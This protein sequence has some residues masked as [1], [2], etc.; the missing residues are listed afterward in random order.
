MIDPDF[1]PKTFDVPGAKLL[2]DRQLAFLADWAA[3]W[4]DA[5][6]KAA[7]SQ[8][9]FAG[10]ATLHGAELFRL[11][12][13][14]DC[15]GWPQT[16]R[17]QALHE[18]RRGFAFMVGGDQH[19]STIVHHGIDDWNDAGWSFCVP[20]I[21]NF[22]PRAWVP[23]TPGGNR[24][25]GMPDYTGKFLDGLGNHVTVWAATNPGKPTGRE[26][27][28]LHDRM[29][30]YGIVRFNKAERTITI[31]CWPRYADP[32]NPDERQY[33]GW[34]KTISQLDNYGR[35]AVRYLPTIKVRGMADPVLQV[36]DEADGE[37]VYTLRIKG[38]SFRPKVFREGV[39]TLKVGEPGT[40]KMKTLTGIQSLAPEKSRMIRVKF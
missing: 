30:G 1:D 33:P 40:E 32:S 9:V 6:M 26:P 31:E 28:A 20:S 25:A 21:A 18:L 8:T 35:R 27:A 16:G 13:D 39:Y 14:L 23:L 36:I 15:N 12:A 38:S 24:E 5:D 2:G 3:D 29:P 17:N 34:P 7:L 4:R 37:I 19:L 22:Y 10:V 11:V